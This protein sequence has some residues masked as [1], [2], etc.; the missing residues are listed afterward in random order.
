[1]FFF[2]LFNFFNEIINYDLYLGF[3]KVGSLKLECKKLIYQEKEVYQFS[4]YLNSDKN[5]SL[6]FEINDTLISYADTDFKTLFTYKSINEKNYKEQCS[7]YFD[8]KNSKIIYNDNSSFP[9]INEIKDILTFWFYI[10]KIIAKKEMVKNCFLHH[11]K[12]NYEV[13][14]EKK[15][16][17][18]INTKIGSFYVYEICPQTKPKAKILGSIYIQEGKDYLPLIIKTNFLGGLLKAVI[19]SYERF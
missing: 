8:Y 7:I 18:F 12:K 10:R 17:L 9:L 5:L 11:N 19:R 16:R 4:S 1:M 14:L 13:I 3:I 6:F 15:R 2:F